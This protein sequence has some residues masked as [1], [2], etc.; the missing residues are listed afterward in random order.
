MSDEQRP[1]I[2]TDVARL[3]RIAGWAAAFGAVLALICGALPPHWRAPCQA[4]AS[5]CRG[6]L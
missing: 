6:G 2:A 1:S 5:L 3:K 4:L